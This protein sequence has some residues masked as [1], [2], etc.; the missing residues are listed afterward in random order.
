MKEFESAFCVLNLTEATQRHSAH[1]CICTQSAVPAAF[2]GELQGISDC[3]MLRNSSS[4]PKEVLIQ[5]SLA[6][7]SAPV[8]M[9]GL[10]GNHDHGIPATL[11][12]CVMCTV[13][14]CCRFEASSTLQI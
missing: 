2:A 10:I 5:L 6:Q 11:T 9:T 7:H 4:V 12:V 13:L 14:W 8:P 1:A 3:R